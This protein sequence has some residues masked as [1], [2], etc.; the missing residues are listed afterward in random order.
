MA[1]FPDDIKGAIDKFA[2]F[3]TKIDKEV[4]RV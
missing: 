3:L 2:A 4:S 1:V